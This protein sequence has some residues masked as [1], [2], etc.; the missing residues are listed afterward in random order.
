MLNQVTVV[1]VEP[2]KTHLPQHAWSHGNATR[3]SARGR[4]LRMRI[5]RFRKDE[6]EKGGLR[7]ELSHSTTGECR[8]AAAR[9]WLAMLTR[10]RC[11]RRGRRSDLRVARLVPAR[12]A[13][14]AVARAKPHEAHAV[15]F[16]GAAKRAVQRA[17]RH[18]VRAARPWRVV[19]AGPSS[20][21]WAGGREGSLS[22]RAGGGSKS[23]FLARS[24]H[25]ASGATA[26]AAAR[27]ILVPRVI[28]PPRV[29]PRETAHRGGYRT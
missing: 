21:A 16:A 7:A 24:R 17:L 28:A 25:P 6:K 5:Y 20:R 12:A 1:C 9:G 22:S 14:V 3:S 27:S 18:R 29:R 13:A 2:Q 19:R 26:T 8:A 4:G 10:R 23:W 15:G 11:G